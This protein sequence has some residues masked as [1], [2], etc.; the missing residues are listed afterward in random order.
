MTQ[1]AWPFEDPP[2]VA[3]ITVRQIVHG[4]RPILLVAH[5]DDDG[6][7]QFLTGEDLD[8]ADGMLVS[9]KSMIDRDPSLAELADL[10]L[11]WHAWRDQVGSPWQ[12]GPQPEEKAA[13]QPEPG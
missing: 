12:R 5:D 4:A 7:W 6:S 13:E 2:N 8:V 10:P 1:D 11:G 3:A 9:L